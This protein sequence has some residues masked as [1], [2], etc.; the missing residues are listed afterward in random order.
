MR[1]FY[2]HILTIILS[3]KN[4]IN[5]RFGR[6]GRN[7]REFQVFQLI[8]D[9]LALLGPMWTDDYSPAVVATETA[10]PPKAYD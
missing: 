5:L 7:D 6:N 8:C 9:N 2:S 3:Q 10:N 4:L 1:T